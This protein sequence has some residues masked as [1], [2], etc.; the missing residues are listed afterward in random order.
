MPTTRSSS[1]TD[2]WSQPV[3]SPGC[4]PSRTQFRRPAPTPTGSPAALSKRGATV[5]RT[6]ADRLTVQ[7]LSA[8]LFG[9]VAIEAGAVIIELRADGPDLETIF[10]SL[11]HPNEHLS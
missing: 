4:C 8:E 1:T 10:E 5:R 3:P 11:I 2:G 9:R 6:Q 7:N